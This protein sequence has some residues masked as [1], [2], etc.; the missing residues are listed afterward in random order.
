MNNQPPVQNEPAVAPRDSESHHQNGQRVVHLIA[1]SG[2]EHGE[3]VHRQSIAQPVR[4]KR[5][6]RN[7]DERSERTDKEKRSIRSA[8]CH[9]LARFG[10]FRASD[11]QIQK[12]T[13]TIALDRDTK[14]LAALQHLDARPVLHVL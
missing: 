11:W 8:D 12:V 2:L 1:D 4:P 7:A 13:S 6:E 5:T 10:V 3:H 9:G 14:E